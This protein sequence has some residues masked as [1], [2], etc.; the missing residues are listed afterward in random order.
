MTDE[1]LKQLA[2]D[3]VENRVFGSWMIPENEQEDTLPIVFMPLAFGAAGH[4]DENV[5]SLYE[6]VSTT[7]RFT[8]KNYPVFMTMRTL[9]KV[10]VEKLSPM[11]ERLRDMRKLFLEEV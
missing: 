9:S 2:L 10:E 5:C 3:V 1:E 7:K 11:I 6:Y 8:S 4:L